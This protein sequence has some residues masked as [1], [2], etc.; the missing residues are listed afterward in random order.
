[1]PVI[2][3]SS[4]SRDVLSL[5]TQVKAHTR[6][7]TDVSDVSCDTT[8]RSMEVIMIENAIRELHGAGVAKY[9][10]G[11]VIDQDSSAEKTIRR[12]FQEILNRVPDI[13][14]DPGHAKKSLEKALCKIFKTAKLYAGLAGRVARWFIRLIKRCELEAKEAQKFSGDYMSVLFSRYWSHTARH[15]STMP[16]D[17]MCPCMNES[18]NLNEG[19]HSRVSDAD[20]SS[21]EFV[22]DEA[23]AMDW[24]TTAPT[25]IDD[26]DSSKGTKEAWTPCAT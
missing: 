4:P 12:V 26:I 11:V 6:Q 22:E 13:H 15:Y 18:M 1:M 20:F 3:M 23:D 16:C 19:S 10:K 25:S 2:N 7:G 21:Q 8:S 14:T 5:Q 24:A 17:S 9:I